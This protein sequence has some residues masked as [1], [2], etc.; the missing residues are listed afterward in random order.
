M[1]FISPVADLYII[2]LDTLLANPEK[3]G[4]GRQGYYFA[5]NGEHT[6][7]A[8]SRA[9]GTALERL[10]ISKS[11]EPTTLNEEEV[12][13][14]GGTLVRRLQVITRLYFLYID[15]YNTGTRL[16]VRHERKV[17]CQ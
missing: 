2:L 1:F 14:Y 6:W 5:E 10:G 9:I 7:L 16:C 11:V 8:I 3:A 17:P 12:T 15:A 4:H 13:R